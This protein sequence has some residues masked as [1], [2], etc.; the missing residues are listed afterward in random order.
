MRLNWLRFQQSFSSLWVTATHFLIVYF[1]WAG[2]IDAFSWVPHE[3]LFT[4][5]GP[6]TLPHQTLQSND[7][8]NGNVTFELISPTEDIVCFIKF[9]SDCLKLTAN[10]AKKT[11]NVKIKRHFA[12]IVKTWE[13]FIP[14]E[15]GRVTLEICPSLF[16][17]WVKFYPNDGQRAMHGFWMGNLPGRII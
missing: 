3:Q 1:L 14:F 11:W 10:V 8:L 13:G 12:R 4:F 17:L 7:S 16:Q 15:E 2:K 9:G 5:L 6:C